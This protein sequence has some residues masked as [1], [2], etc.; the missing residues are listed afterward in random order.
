MAFPCPM[1]SCNARMNKNLSTPCAN[2]LGYPKTSKQQSQYP[3][4]QKSLTFR[5]NNRSNLQR[6]PTKRT[7]KLADPIPPHTPPHGLP[8]LIYAINVLT[9]RPP[10]IRQ[11]MRPQHTLHDPPIPS[12]L[13]RPIPRIAR[14]RRRKDI[15]HIPIPHP[16]TSAH[17]TPHKHTATATAP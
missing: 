2:I 10:T 5:P 1:D 13:R 9:R 7:V 4:P 16:P 12:R 14:L 15:N 8:V 11:R 6:R 17:Y 3:L